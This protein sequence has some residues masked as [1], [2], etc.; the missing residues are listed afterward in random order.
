MHTNLAGRAG[1]WSAAHWKT[2]AFGWLA[3]A[4]AAVVIGGAVGAKQMKSW[5]ITNGDSRR[6]EQILDQAS[7][8]TPAR[9]SVLIQSKSLT[10]DREDFRAG[11]H[12][13]V[14]AFQ[15]KR[16]VTG[17]GAPRRPRAAG[18]VSADLHSA[19]V[20]FDIKGKVSNAKDKA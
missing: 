17:I 7:F 19:L 14:R 3:F 16:D 13:V 15:G 4:V 20:Q 8:K 2:A 1:R 10:V 11:N 9:E 5:A 6:A 18:L 12:T